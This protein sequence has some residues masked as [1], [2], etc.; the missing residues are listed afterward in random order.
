M[1]VKPPTNAAA[2]ATMLQGA[3]RWYR[4]ACPS[5]QICIGKSLRFE[6]VVFERLR[7]QLMSGLLKLFQTLQW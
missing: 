5:L 6:F 3:P 1:Q 7:L 4:N 2:S